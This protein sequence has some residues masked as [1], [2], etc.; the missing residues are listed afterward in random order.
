MKRIANNEDTNK[1]MTRSIAQ[2]SM[3][4]CE[5]T[6]DGFDIGD[7]PATSQINFHHYLPIPMQFNQFV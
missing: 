3:K 4:V 5:P 7:V 1:T 2:R 6:F